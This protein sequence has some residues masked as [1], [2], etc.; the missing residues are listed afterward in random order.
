MIK[1]IC[2]ILLAL[3]FTN[4]IIFSFIKFLYSYYRVNLK[5]LALL[6][7]WKRDKNNKLDLVKN[8]RLIKYCCK[9]VDFLWE[10]FDLFDNE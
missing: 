8:N 2:Y 3:F 10:Y 7:R 9:L 1:I 5:G 4:L 6:P